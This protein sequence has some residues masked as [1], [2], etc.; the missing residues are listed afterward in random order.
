[1]VGDDAQAI[2]SF[3]A[4]TVRNILDFPQRFDPPAHVVTLERNYRSSGAILAAANAVIA[5]APERFAKNLWTERPHG[6][7]PALV[8]VAD[9]AD[10]ARFVADARARQSRGGRHAQKPGGAVPRLSP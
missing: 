2:Y 6:S 1:M 7:L 3:R 9:D 8:T 5:L 4:A 10:Q